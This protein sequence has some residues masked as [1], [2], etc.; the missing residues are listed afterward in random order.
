MTLGRETKILLALLGTLSTGFVGVLGSKLFVPR[1]PDGAGPDVHLPALDHEDGPIVEPPSFD[2][3]ERSMF[4]ATDAPSGGGDPADDMTAGASGPGSL[5]EPP[6]FADADATIDDAGSRFGGPA[7]EESAGFPRSN[8]FGM[9]DDGLAAEP[10]A[11]AA[12]DPDGAGDDGMLAEAMIAD[13]AAGDAD[14]GD[15]FG[16]S[17]AFE[18]QA[19][20]ADDRFGGPLSMEPPSFAGGQPDSTGFGGP[21]ALEPPG[22]FTPPADAMPISSGGHVVVAGDTWWSIAERAYGDGRLY[23]PLFAWNRSIDPRVSLV[24]GTALEVPPLNSLAT[25]HAGL[26]PS[27]LV[28]STPTSGL[29][30]AS[31][32]APLEQPAFGGPAVAGGNAVVVREGDTLISIAREQLGSSARWRELYEANREVLGRSPGPLTPG[33]QLVLP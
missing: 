9:A 7:G 5:L 26:V 21:A 20:S 30:Q 1:P 3:L 24:P 10:P 25:A 33:T 18:E 13:D 23:K 15:G 32:V 4:S 14:T 16:S 22:R 31:V 11:D 19:G 28:A 6:T 17:A 2:R 12:V 8:R 27:D 29:V